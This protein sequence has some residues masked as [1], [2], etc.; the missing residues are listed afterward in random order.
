M[1]TNQA[2]DADTSRGSGLTS[3]FQVST[4][5]NILLFVIQKE[6]STRMFTPF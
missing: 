1:S 6:T 5:D 3:G 2:G 4:N